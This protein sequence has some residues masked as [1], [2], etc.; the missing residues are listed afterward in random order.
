MLPPQSKPWVQKSQLEL[1]AQPGS[2]QML[3]L[4]LLSL[5]EQSPLS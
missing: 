2:G 3:L 5:T 4:F 1:A